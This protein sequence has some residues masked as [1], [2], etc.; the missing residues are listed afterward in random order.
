MERR[1]A[2]DERRKIPRFSD[3]VVKD[4]T[5]QVKTMMAVLCLLTF[6]TAVY[7]LYVGVV[8]GTGKAL[9]YAL[10]VSVIF[11]LLTTFSFRY[12]QSL[13]DYIANESVTNLNRSMERLSL[14]LVLLCFCYIL[15]AVVY[16][17]F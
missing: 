9:S 2:D 6:I 7:K 12:Y 17:I 3:P 1:G 11:F 4:Y 13:N 8:V 16:A 14:F 10:F 5:R 15:Y